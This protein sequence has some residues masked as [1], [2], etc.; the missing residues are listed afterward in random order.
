MG[1]GRTGRNRRHI[2]VTCFERPFERPRR[3]REINVPYCPPAHSGAGDDPRSRQLQLPAIMSRLDNLLTF[4]ALEE[5]VAEHRSSGV[6]RRT[7]TRRFLRPVRRI[8][9]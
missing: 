7:A 6:I 1:E 2:R 4:A 3:R 9:C 5:S 8:A